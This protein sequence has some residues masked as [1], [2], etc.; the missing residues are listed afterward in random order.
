V[1]FE[2]VSHV[3]RI[4]GFAFSECASLRSIVIPASVV[5]IDAHA[6]RLCETLERVE[7]E[8]ALSLVDC[9][10]LAFDL[11]PV[12][13]QLSFAEMNSWHSDLQLMEGSGEWTCDDFA[14][15]DEM[16]IDFIVLCR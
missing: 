1:T 12:F 16:L 11:C 13:N 4:E 3:R 8:G 7:F 6:F 9:D 10:A 15:V 5:K 2:P 14:A